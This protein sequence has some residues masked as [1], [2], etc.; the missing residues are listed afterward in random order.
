[1]KI[2]GLGAGGWGLVTVMA[3]ITG[4]SHAAFQ[5]PYWS[6]RAASLAGAFTAVPD[7][8]TGVFYNP[9]AS[10]KIKR[11]LS[12]LSYAKLYAGLDE[13]NLSLAQ[14]GLLVPLAEFGTVGIGWGSLNS[15]SLYREDTVAVSYAYTLSDLLQAHYSGSIAI[16]VSIRYLT[17]RF[18]LDERT[19][20]DPIFKDGNRIQ[21][22]ACDFHLYSV[23]DPELLPGLSLGISIR[24]VNEPDIGFRSTE[25][26]PREVAGGFLYQWRNLSFP[27]DVSNRS[28]DTRPHLG[29]EISLWDKQLVLRL[30]SDLDQVGSGVGIVRR[31]DAR[32]ILSIDYAFL[33]PLGLERT[34]G[35]HHATVGIQF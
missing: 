3:L 12:N 20:S 28:G 8:P 15:A 10:A 14:L 6:A 33:W 5:D 26:R 29:G 21:N 23:P 30:G 31:S 17:R 35:S 13:V 18:L 11:M 32:W 2:W 19:A 9:A 27:I 16:G 25:R 24:S 7:D 1:M 4:P 34:S 22:A